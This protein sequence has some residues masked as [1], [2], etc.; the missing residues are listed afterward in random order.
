MTYPAVVELIA[1][2]HDAAQDATD[3]IEGMTLAEFMADKRTN[4]AV[5]MNLIII[6]EIAARIMDRH[7][8]FARTHDQVPWQGMRGMRNRI[9]HGYFE[10]DLTIVWETIIQAIPELL[11]NLPPPSNRCVLE[12]AE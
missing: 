3:F 2:L 8:D 10:I 5:V 6:G 11:R 12:A 4:Q 7:P 9:A 1:Q